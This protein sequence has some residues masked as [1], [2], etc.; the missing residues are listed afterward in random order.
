MWGGFGFLAKSHVTKKGFKPLAF[1][2]KAILHA[3]LTI[4]L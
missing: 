1:L 2:S 3:L 4:A